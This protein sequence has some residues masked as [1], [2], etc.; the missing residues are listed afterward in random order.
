MHHNQKNRILRSCISY[1]ISFLMTIFI[2]V[3][4]LLIVI[5]F[6]CFNEESLLKN[7]SSYGY[8][9]YVYEDIMEDLMALTLPT[10]LPSSVYESAITQTD[11]HNDVNGNLKAQFSGVTYQSQKDVIRTELHMS[12]EQ[13]MNENEYE[14][15]EA[16]KSSVNVYVNEVAQE[17]ERYIEMPFVKYI[18][19]A[20]NIF[21]KV[22]LP[23][24]L[25]MLVMTAITVYIELQLHR[26]LHRA[27]RFVCYSCTG[28]ALMLLSVPG[29]FFIEK[30]HYRFNLTP[31]SFY[32]LVTTYIDNILKLFLYCG[33]LWV[34]V[35]I[36]MFIAT[37]LAKK[38]NKRGHRVKHG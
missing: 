31:E 30:S 19:K 11:V 29:Y 24:L 28:C 14:P 7:M 13:Y 3:M 10:G 5:R 12:I 27:L 15:T 21:D 6:G 2:T 17:Y 25:A 33:L 20:K 16:E 38:Y 18:V 22:F 26:W 34:V 35:A 1:V 23:A 4:T 36:I 8:Y 37:T 9:D 32:H